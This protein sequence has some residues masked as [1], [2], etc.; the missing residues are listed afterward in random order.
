MES[1]TSE[2]NELLQMVQNAVQSAKFNDVVIINTNQD[3]KSSSSDPSEEIILTASLDTSSGGI[4]WKRVSVDPPTNTNTHLTSHPFQNDIGIQLHLRTKKWL[5]P[6]LQDEPRNQLYEKAIQKATQIILCKNTLSKI[7]VLDIGAGTGLLGMIAA[8]AL[9]QNSNQDQNRNIQ[10]ISLEMASAMSRIARHIIQCNQLHNQI[11]ILPYHSCDAQ[12]QLPQRAHLCISELLESGFLG[13]GIIP[14]LRDAWERHL[15][16]DAIMIPQ[17]ARIY[18]QIVESEDSVAC[19]RGPC[20][21]ILKNISTRFSTMPSLTNENG[22]EETSLLLSENPEEENKKGYLVPIRADALLSKSDVKTL[23]DPFLALEFDFTSAQSMP[24]MDG[25]SMSFQLSPINSGKAHGVLFWWELDLWEGLTY[26]TKPPK[27]RNQKDYHW[28]DHW[29]QCLFVFHRTHQDCETLE[30]GSFFTCT[31]S[32]TDTAIAFHIP[33]TTKSSSPTHSKKLKR[34]PLNPITKYSFARTLSLYDAHRIKAYRTALEYTLKQKGTQAPILDLSDFSMGAIIAATFKE[35]PAQHVHSVESGDTSLSPWPILSSKIAQIGN[36]LPQPNSVFQVWNTRPE[37]LT[38]DLLFP[39]SQQKIQIVVAEPYY[40]QLQGF[41]LQEALNFYYILQGLQCK[42]ILSPDFTVLPQRARIMGCA[43]ELPP[44]MINAY[45]P[46]SHKEKKEI[47]GLDHTPLYQWHG[48]DIDQYDIPF[49]MWQYGYTSLTDP[50]ELDCL[51]YE[52]LDLS[53]SISKVPAWK[54]V[55]FRKDGICHGMLIWVEYD[56][57][58]SSDRTNICST[59]NEHHSQL[60]RRLRQPDKV[61]KHQDMFCFQSKFG[62]D[63]EVGVETH[64]FSL[65]VERMSSEPKAS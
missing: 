37:M 38:P 12:F 54:K 11:Q 5:F 50:F 61:I 6:M 53:K 24:P 58:S 65:K 16:P 14:T 59:N 48:R 17:R 31:A 55:P 33:R 13:E 10:I 27:Y 29:Q 2:E 4:V 35:N 45:G 43:V 52:I 8:R 18:A 32:H 39:S 40:E 57:P 63:M 21:D 47:C 46:F 28:Q 60:I 30:R 1:T 41:P 19:Y 9:L 3:K 49:Y 56:L 34:T 25:R 42:D 64:S 51:E 23:T 7:Q 22:D 44:E 15:E 26:S 36:A 62:G 20:T